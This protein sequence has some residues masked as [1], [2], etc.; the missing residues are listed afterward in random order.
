M[1]IVLFSFLSFA[2]ILIY[3][4]NIFETYALIST[5]QSLRTTKIFAAASSTTSWSL[6]R[7]AANGSIILFTIYS[8]FSC[9]CFDT[10]RPL[11]TRTIF[12]QFLLIGVVLGINLINLT[13]FENIYHVI[14]SAV[15]L[16]CLIWETFPFCLL[17]DLILQDCDDL[18]E[19]LSHSNWVDAEPRY[20][21][22][23]KIYL[24]HLQ[25]PINF[26][27]GGIFPISLT[28]NIK[29]R[30]IELLPKIKH[31]N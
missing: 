17:C 9:S 10:L 21:S 31:F 4:K 11:I 23:L 30:N 13:Y 15:Y 22:T 3:W 25:Q 19:L 27:A 24:H 18:A 29:V 6:S 7:I 5:R 26:N 8:S 12:V 20:K 1:A 16:T 14:S 2:D 28:S